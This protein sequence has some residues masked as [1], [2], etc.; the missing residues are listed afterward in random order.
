M[1]SICQYDGGLTDVRPRTRHY[2]PSPLPFLNLLLSSFLREFAKVHRQL[3]REIRA[4]KGS[5]HRISGR[6]PRRR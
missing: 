5:L 4:E 3:V 1:L 2:P 6:T